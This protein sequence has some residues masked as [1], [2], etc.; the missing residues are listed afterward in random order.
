[1]NSRPNYHWHVEDRGIRHVLTSSHDRLSSTARSSAR[2]PRRIRSFDQLLSYKDVCRSR[3]QIGGPGS[4]LYNLARPHGVSQTGNTLTKL[5]EIAYDPLQRVSTIC[6]VH[7][8]LS[9][10]PIR[11]KRNRQ[12]ALD[13]G[14]IYDFDDDHHLLVSLGT[15]L[16]NSSTTNVL[17]VSRL[18]DHRA[19]FFHDRQR[20]E[21]FTLVLLTMLAFPVPKI[22]HRANCGKARLS[23]YCWEDGEV[24]SSYPVAE[25]PVYE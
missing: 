5:S 3:S 17:R 22:R 1:M 24:S 14:A 10:P 23:V 18:P 8:S 25:L 13:I 12:Q 6:K 4:V 16:Q 11:F 2:K 21:N 19:R 15:G 9:A 7:T 20:T